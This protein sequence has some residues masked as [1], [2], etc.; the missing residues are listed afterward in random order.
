MA[1]ENGLI[2]A[3]DLFTASSKKGFA[4]K[5]EIKEIEDNDNSE[6]LKMKTKNNER[7]RNS[8]LGKSL[9]N[10]NQNDCKILALVNLQ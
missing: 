7:C 10:C 6:A 2:K 8:I 4:M 1:D 9:E 3:G 5:C